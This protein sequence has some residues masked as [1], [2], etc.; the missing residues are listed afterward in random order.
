MVSARRDHCVATWIVRTRGSGSI[1]VEHASSGSA[2]PA[3]VEPKC[4]W[5][6]GVLFPRSR[7][8]SSGSAAFS[9]RQGRSKMAPPQRSTVPRHRSHRDRRRRHRGEPAG[10]TATR[11]ACMSPEPART[12]DRSRSSSTTYSVRG[13]ASRRCE[14]RAG[15]GVELLEYLAPRTGR[16]MPADTQAN[17]DWYWQVNTT[18]AVTPLTLRSALDATHTCH[19][20]PE[21]VDGRMQLVVR[22]PDGHALL[23][24]DSSNLEGKLP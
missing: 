23:L 4:R 12:T 1:K 2:A 14:L 6:R 9:G 24:R 19:A 5:Y 3:G 11:S 21:S 17:D 15:P 18:A 10:T 16:P 13:C 22:D 20:G 7:R 8:Q